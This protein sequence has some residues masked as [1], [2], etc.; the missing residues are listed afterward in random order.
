MNKDVW[1][2]K[3][4]LEEAENAFK[5]SEVPVGAIIIDERE[6]ILVRTSNQ[7]ENAK[8]PCGHAEILAIQEAAKKIGN[9]RLEKCTLYVTLEPCPMCLGA[10]AQARIGKLCFGAYDPKGGAISLGYNLYKDK[11]LN[12]RYPVMGG[13]LHYDASKLMSD[14]FKLRRP[15]YNKPIY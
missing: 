7:K 4:A 14:F 1:F 8:N 12:H 15:N 10:L 11:R 6:N 5:S 2:M 9:W 13:I 3:I